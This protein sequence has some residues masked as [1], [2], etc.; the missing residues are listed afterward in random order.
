MPDAAPTVPVAPAAPAARGGAFRSL[1]HR[2]A[3]IFFLGLLVSNVGSWLQLTGVSY[4]L[5]D[6]TGNAA[7]LGFNVAF[8]FLPMLLLGSW[9]GALADRHDRLRITILT[10]SLLAIQALTLGALVVADVV[11][12]PAVY[13]LSLAVGIIGAFDNPARRGFVTELVPAGD[14]SNAMS[15]NTTVMTG[16]RM[17]GAAITAA[18]IGPLGVGWL[19]VA[20]GVSFGAMLL[21]LLG[22]R[23]AELQPAVRRPPGGSPVREVFAFVRHHPRLLTMFTAYVLVSTFS[24]NY[25]VAMPKV[26]D[27]RWGAAWAFGWVLAAS[28]FGSILGSLATARLRVVSMR[29]F[30]AHVAGLGVAS[31]LL[32]F[33]PGV[34]AGLVVSVAV[35]FSGAAI[36]AAGNA[37]TQQESPPDM[38]GRLL[39]LTAVAFLGSTP[40]GGPATGLVADFVSV[41]WSVAYGG[42]V[43]LVSALLAAWMWK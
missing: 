3:R 32:A 7:D 20:N 8:Q 27:V 12:V 4:L 22:I 36:I 11:T 18:L 9:C 16:S 25:G 6:L 5:Y 21:G 41:E 33:S 29:W 13:A 40:I 10:Q 38:R 1:R 31:I 43:A 42:V 15:L 37:I 39:A 26:A 17:V 2:N 28:G 19:F 30:V 14:M 23:R 35:G 34:A 24:F